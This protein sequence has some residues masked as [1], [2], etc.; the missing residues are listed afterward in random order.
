MYDNANECAKSLSI[1]EINS[2]DTFIVS[3]EFIV[4]PGVNRVHVL[5][6]G[7][8]AGGGSGNA[9][10]GGSGY[11]SASTVEVIEGDVIAVTVG[12]G[13]AGSK[14]IAVDPGD[15]YDQNAYPGEPSSFGSLVWAEGGHV[16]NPIDR[17][18]GDG[19]SG[20]GGECVIYESCHGAPV[21]QMEELEQMAQL[22]EA[23][24]K[25]TTRRSSAASSLPHLLQ[26]EAA[27]EVLT[28]AAE[29][30]AVCL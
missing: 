28:A 21:V 7:G 11:V 3:G 25:A 9:G 17:S 12:R 6:V 18:G 1:T 16:M 26:G 4:R 19:G 29:A 10:G 22:M 20:G 13:G 23:K 5:V 24:D 14:D 8:G 2:K 27:K 15:T 30:A